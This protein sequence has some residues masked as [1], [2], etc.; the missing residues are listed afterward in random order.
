MQFKRKIGLVQKL[1]NTGKLYNNQENNP[2]FLNNNNTNSKELLRNNS[3]R[4]VGTINFNHRNKTNDKAPLIKKTK[5][6][7]TRSK[8]LNNNNSNSFLKRKL[9]TAYRFI[10]KTQH[11]FNPVTRKLNNKFETVINLFND[12]YNLEHYL[13]DNNVLTKYTENCNEYVNKFKTTLE[14]DINHFGLLSDKITRK[15]HICFST[16]KHKQMK[17][18]LISFVLR[19][20]E[21]KQQQNYLDTSY[22]KEN[23]EEY[24]KTNIQNQN[25]KKFAK[26]FLNFCLNEVMNF[27]VD[28][29]NIDI[30]LSTV[31]DQI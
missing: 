24:L 22:T 23:I 15:P 2:V 3:P 26:I 18:L 19:N 10:K 11:K 21:L 25:A 6:K 8:W 12:K 7:N 27:N 13:S 20:I 9:K 16:D 5:K 4:T 31:N 29:E 14:N 17:L 1:P 30:F 28:L